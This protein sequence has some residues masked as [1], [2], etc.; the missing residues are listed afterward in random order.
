MRIVSG[1]FESDELERLAPRLRGGPRLSDMNGQRAGTL[2]PIAATEVIAYDFLSRGGKHLRPFITLGAYHALTGD[3]ATV[4]DRASG[5]GRHE[6]E[7]P[8]AVRRAAVSI[9][10]FHKASLVHDDIEDDDDFRYGDVTLHRRFGT[11]TAINVGDYLIGMGYRLL[12]RESGR[13]G[14]DVVADIL[15]RAA[16]AHVRLSEGQGAELLWRDSRD[17]G[18]TLSDALK[19]YALKTAPAFEA[20]LYSG[21]R[22]AGL[23]DQY[24]E[25]FRQFAGDLG[26]AFQILNDLDDWLGDDHNKL[27]ACGDVL[28]GRPTVLWALALEGLPAQD[29]K[30]IEVLVGNAHGNGRGKIDRVRQ[31]YLQA[32]VFEKALRLVDER[33]RGAR[34]LALRIEPTEL[35]ELLCHLVETVLARPAAIYPNAG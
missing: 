11:P 30:Q 32:G 1:M 8:D 31:L 14:A 7:I 28:G 20:A 16:D 22:L 15:E 29:R 17:K 33:R 18:L 24:A 25:P 10:T 19:I 6:V 13:L 26:V 35:R 27:S 2:D 9:E 4:G 21:V 5:N 34:R 12:S 3:T 23:A